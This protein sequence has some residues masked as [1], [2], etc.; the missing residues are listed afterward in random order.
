MLN[1]KK[2]HQM[3][4]MQKTEQKLKKQKG[5][6][7]IEYALILAAVV[8]IGTVYFGDSGSITSAINTKLDA[9]STK[10]SGTG[11]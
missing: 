4:E 5:A 2:L 7:L 10:I 9:V 3:I 1:E 6:S 11:T 8:G